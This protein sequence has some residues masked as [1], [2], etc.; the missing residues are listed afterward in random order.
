MQFQMSVWGAEKRGFN[1][2]FTIHI[3]LFSFLIF[4]FSMAGGGR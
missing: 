3:A 1:E 4:L 2:R